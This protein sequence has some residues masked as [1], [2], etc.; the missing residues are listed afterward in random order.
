MIE[1]GELA[2][3]VVPFLSAAAGAYGSAVVTK[4]TE[5]GTDAAADATVGVGRKLLGRLLG[6]SRSAQV[7]A[8]VTDL[9]ENPGDEAFAAAVFAQVKRALAED[10]E[11]RDDIAAMVAAAPA[12]PGTF[13]VTVT[14]STGVQIGNHNV[15]SV[16]QPPAAR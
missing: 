14:G 10:G 13:T 9:G 2:G 4:A 7:G 3:T 11:L 12:Q 1:V 15:L 6:S 16:H 5:Q 8:A